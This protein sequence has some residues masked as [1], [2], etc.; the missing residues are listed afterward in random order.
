MDAQPGRLELAKK[1]EIEGSYLSVY[2]DL[3][4]QETGTAYMLEKPVRPQAEST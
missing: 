3:F 2:A 4:D 1:F